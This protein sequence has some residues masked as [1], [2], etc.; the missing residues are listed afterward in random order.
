M[1]KEALIAE[2]RQLAPAERREI[3]AEFAGDGTE[4]KAPRVFLS[5]SRTD[6]PFVQ[7]LMAGLERGGVRVW[8]D[9]RELMVGE[10]YLVATEQGLRDSEYCVVI[11]SRYSME[12]AEVLRE[13]TIAQKV[14]TTIVPV[15][16]HDTELAGQLRNLQWVDFRFHFE[17]PLAGLIAQ[18]Q[19]RI[20]QT[21]VAQ[22]LHGA[23]KPLNTSRDVLQRF[24]KGV[25]SSVRAFLL[26]FFS[27]GLVLMFAAMPFFGGKAWA[28]GGFIL[29]YAALM[30][31]TSFQIADRRE[32][33]AGVR[34]T[35]WS[36]V[37]GI[38]AFS[39]VFCVLLPAKLRW[40]V[41][42]TELPSFV[43]LIAALVVSELSPSFRRWLPARHGHKPDFLSV[44]LRSRL[45]PPPQPA[46]P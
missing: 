17:G 24:Q 5:Y 35:L 25:P 33:R 22:R 45:R 44:W 2:L 28:G 32:T 27:S 1:R 4:A 26:L 9:V 7:D 31:Y 38:P 30:V 37:F 16:L 6:L 19:G 18:L 42:W 14:G 34:S 3:L 43:L 11:V 21:L 12:S 41:A 23:T 20:N 8:F 29:F 39:A 36:L 40:L 46:K 10:D 13:L 15:L